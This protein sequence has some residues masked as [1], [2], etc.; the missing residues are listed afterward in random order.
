MQRILRS[1]IDYQDGITTSEDLQVNFK[2]LQDSKLTWVR[3]DDE[4]IYRFI[5]D[6]ATVNLGEAPSVHTVKDYFTRGED[7]EVLERLKDV[8]G[9]PCYLR[10]NFATLLNDS[11]GKQH[12]AIFQK[13]LSTSKEI[14][15]T[16]LTIEEGKKKT[17]LFGVKDAIAYISDHTFDLLPTETNAEVRGDAREDTG[18]AWEEYGAT[19]ANPDG[20]G[21]IL[22]IQH[23]DSVCRGARN[24]D[25]WIH[26]GF[27]GE[28]KTTLALNWCYNL[29]TKYRTNVLF[30]SLEMKMSALRRSV[31]TLHSGN[32]KFRES[33]LVPKDFR[34][35][36]YRK[37]RDAE[38]NSDEE[39]I[40]QEVLRDFHE[41]PEHCRF[42]IWCPAEEVSIAKIRREAETMNQQMDLGFLVIDHG[43]LVKD[44]GG[45]REYNTQVNAVVRDAKRLALHFNNGKGIPVL[46]LF[47]IN[48]QGKMAA[49]KAAGEYTA[50]A[51]AQANE[52]EKSADVITTTYLSKELRQQGRTIVSCIKNRDNPHFDLCELGVDFTSRKI[53]DLSMAERGAG[54]GMG[55]DEIDA[56]LLDATI[57]G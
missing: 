6:F 29:T 25:L 48:R 30:A 24:G 49:E 33:G 32:P 42:K 54:L 45:H 15:V 47:Q 40:Y 31:Y 17:R 35:L 28:L 52:C 44:D 2:R 14:A 7:Q 34:S 21:K 38:L 56:G 5:E 11:L 53:Y 39:R 27:P 1:V 46:L 3:A 20:I 18:K 41:D 43:L 26:A 51:L 57:G 13:I 10:N 12:A 19:K 22:G 4:K 9:A 8:A 23:I 37:I 36:D 50:A 16:G 55:M